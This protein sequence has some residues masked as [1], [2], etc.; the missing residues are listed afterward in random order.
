M[1]RAIRVGIDPSRAGQVAVQGS[2]NTSNNG[3]RS[4]RLRDQYQYGVAVQGSRSVSI[5]NRVQHRNGDM[6]RGSWPYD[7]D[8]AS[9]GSPNTNVNG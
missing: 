2:P 1:P 5:N 7:I 9:N 6:I 8:Y 4:V 3:I